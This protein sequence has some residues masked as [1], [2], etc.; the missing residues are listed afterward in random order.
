MNRPFGR[1][2]VHALV[3]PVVVFAVVSLQPGVA[4]AE[5]KFP[6]KPVQLISPAP[7]GNGPDVIARVIADQLT[8]IWGEQVL[9]INKP[10]GSGLLAANAAAGAVPDGYTLYVANTSS[11]VALPVV[12]KLPFDMQT[13]FKPIG[14]IGEQPMIIAVAP[15]LGVNTLGEL[16]A[17]AKK[18][19]GEILFAAATRDS[20][21][22]YTTELLLSKAGAS[23]TY[24]FYKGGTSQA[25]G[26]VMGGRLSVV[27]ESWPALSGAIAAG[28]IKPIAVTSAKRMPEHPD[29][30]T[31]S[32]TFPN[33]EVTAWIPMLAPAQTP[34]EI[35]EKVNK[36]IRTIA[37]KPE[38]QAKL[39]SL[40]TY[41]RPMTVQELT[42]FM[43]IER[44]KWLP[45]VQKVSATPDK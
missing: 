14:V 18:K 36:D 20:I 8:K 31:A 40:G 22:R 34:D 11:I 17:L 21:P 4:G 41:V 26:D 44:K 10:G 39:G 33:F 24:V 19:P 1:Q 32:E 28:S 5:V 6:T 42:A 37:D 25:I 38:V 15:S 43:E 27:V 45:A 29:V 35:I 23:M 3:A 12:Q 2:F 30:P 9:V 13:A 7:A 16:M